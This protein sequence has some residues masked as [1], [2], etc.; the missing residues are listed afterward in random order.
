MTMTLADQTAMTRQDG[1]VTDEP[2]ESRMVNSRTADGSICPNCRPLPVLLC[3]IC[4]RTA[5]CTLSK[6]TGLPRCG[7]CDRRQA[8]C[9]VCGRMRGIHS[10]TAHAPV[11]G[12]SSRTSATMRTARRPS[13]SG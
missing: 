5:P 1:R 4:G 3:S 8:H 2:A 12:P 11:C 10:G 7:G 6:L 13:S 9:T